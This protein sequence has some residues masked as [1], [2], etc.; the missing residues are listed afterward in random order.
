MAI[1]MSIRLAWHDNGWN[2]HI[3]NKPNEN[4][5]CVGQYSY[6]GD[7]IAGN[8][9][10][11]F[12]MNH[13]GGACK[14]FPCRVACGLSVNAFGKDP[15]TVEAAPP[16]FFKQF[17]QTYTKTSLVMNLPP[18]TACT[19][20]YEPMFSYETKTDGKVD[21][22]KR[23][24]AAEAYF[25]QFE[26]GKSLIFYYAGYSNPFSEN[27]ENNY[28]VVGI[29]RLSKIGSFQFYPNVTPKIS[30]AFAGG[31]VWQ[32]PVTS[33]YPNEG[34]CIPYQNYAGDEDKLAKILV[35]PP[36][37]AP[38]K[39]GSREV[40][41][42]DA[43]EV[44]N[45]LIAA[46]DALIELGDTSENWRVRRDW[47]NSVLA[48][49]WQ[50]RGAYPGFPA[51]LDVLKMQPLIS[52]CLKLTTNAAQKNF[53]ADVRAFVDGAN[54]GVAQKFPAANIPKIRRNCQ[55]LGKDKLDLLFNVMSRFDIKA[56]QMRAIIDD[57]R[58]KVSVT[59]TVDEMT[60]NPYVIF[61]QY[62]GFDS[63]DT[64][65]LYKIDNGVIPSPQY[66]LNNL[67]DVDSAER[68]RAF[69][70]DEL[71][72]IPA[73][74][75]V[76][77]AA[78]LNAVN[79][80]LDRLPA[81]KQ[82][83]F[84][85]TNFTVDKAVLDG[86]LT[87]RTDCGSQ[88][89]DDNKQADNSTLYLY[90]KD[91]YEDERTVEDALTKLAQRADIQ[92]R[93]AVLPAAFKRNL[94]DATS[95]L[96]KSCP[97]EYDKIL[98]NQA[99][100]C[101][102]IF[103]K[104]LCVISGKA[105]T[106]KTTVIRAL[107][108]TIERVHGVGTSFRLLAPTGKAS[109]R[110][111]LLT[112]KDASTIHSFLASNGW[113]NDNFTLKRSGGSKARDF[114]TIIIDECSMIDLNL[115]ATLLRTINWNSVQRLILIGD[116]NQLPPIGRGKVFVDIINWLK[117]NFPDNIGT[118]T[119]NVRQLVNQ[120]TGNGCG[121][122]ELADVFIQENQRSGDTETLKLARDEIFNKILLNGNG[123]VDKDL[124]VYFWQDRD[125]LEKILLDTVTRDLGTASWF[126]TMKSNPEAIQVISPYRGEFYGTNS[127]NVV[128][129]ANFKSFGVQKLLDGIG[130]SDKVIQIV[131][132]PKSNAAYAFDWKAH[133]AVRAEIF[134]GEIGIVRQ[135]SFDKGSKAN[136][137][138]RFQVN[139]SG[140][141]RQNL[142]YSYGGELGQLDGKFIPEQKVAE[143][144]ELAYAI[145]VHK[146]Q[147]SEFDFVYIVLPQ[148][149]SH[150]LSMELLYT[151][152][153][154][155]QKKVTVFLQNDIS[156]L[157]TMSRADKSAV[158][159]INSSVFEFAPL[160]DDIIR[161]NGSWYESGKKISTLTKYFVRS[162][163]E[164]IIANLLADRDIPFRYEEPLY[165]PDGTMFLPDFTVTVNGE[166]FYWEHLGR[167]DL[168]EYREH[169]A[170][171]QA[172]Y[173]KHFPGKLLTTTESNNLTKDAEKII[174]AF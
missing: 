83:V 113:I 1:H 74:S 145:S 155:A 51:V 10:L 111:K 47:L 35:M 21:N 28:V 114:N 44:I 37:R 162:K 23:K 9:D 66:G 102:K 13:C 139:F 75:F 150:L 96:E 39:Y 57:K 71:K 115:F 124:A 19:W 14:N 49:I 146:A 93:L 141:T 167:L 172:W 42:D 100:I 46:V 137:I 68:L 81:W 138:K 22:N 133:K 59:A 61:E 54:N 116:P 123:N 161:F 130:Y 152:L 65:P 36:N 122:L 129:Q 69:C 168:P 62:V 166:D 64:I 87:Q 5:Y 174:A 41:N 127:L 120:V 50:A 60:A 80:R 73:H 85:M 84:G 82:S 6:P 55:L 171:K 154:R 170:K 16:D 135:H 94:R 58:E 11:P 103:T 90:L 147:G 160:P 40:S 107:L 121:I 86:A 163:S 169:W 78:I 92:P 148:R 159:K 18:Y 165:A 29:S 20:C 99:N 91:T 32:M 53:V 109:E 48:E 8:R 89:L 149:D 72:K 132:R 101:M 119:D 12:E 106:G 128:M 38:F 15:I 142:A 33:N 151:A 156:T 134:N 112:G 63:D 110:I 24:A 77:A 153:T 118:L 17:D 30:N 25:K 126:D 131:N 140:T 27:E 43:T 45:Q 158:L 144:L 136:W 108:D 26:A 76:K 173:D 164:A 56:A 104:P 125:D 88:K 97:Q 95:P 3:C 7:L 105:G 79:M 34:F 157:A 98:D 143:N 31:L 4:T 70:V 67:L 117:K 2:G 52:D